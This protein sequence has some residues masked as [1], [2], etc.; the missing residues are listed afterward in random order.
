MRISE[1][2]RLLTAMQKDLGDLEVVTAEKDESGWIRLKHGSQFDAVAPMLEN[3]AWGETI[4]A[5]VGK[6]C[7]ELVL[8]ADRQRPK[9]ALVKSCKGDT[10]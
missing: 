6:S 9:L 5:L 3:G 8:E 1:A 4:C 2:I 7:E 10:E